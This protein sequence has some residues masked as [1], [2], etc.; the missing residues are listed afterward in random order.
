MVR[1]IFAVYEDVNLYG[2]V[3]AYYRN[4]NYYGRL[5]SLYELFIV[6]SMRRHEEQKWK[7]I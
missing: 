1:S 7:T 5:K 2:Y 4:R 6:Y 3:F